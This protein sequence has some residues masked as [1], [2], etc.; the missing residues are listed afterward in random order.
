MSRRQLGYGSTSK[1]CTKMLTGNS[2]RKPFKAAVPY[3]CFFAAA[4][5]CH[6]KYMQKGEA[7]YRKGAVLYRDHRT[8]FLVKKQAATIFTAL[9][10]FLIKK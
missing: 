8:P 2:R 9:K 4:G 5:V 10:M 6:K 1:P 3:G 7:K